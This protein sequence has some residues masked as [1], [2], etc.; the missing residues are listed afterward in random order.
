MDVKTEIEQGQQSDVRHILHA[1]QGYFTPSHGAVLPIP[2]P[3]VHDLELPRKFFHMFGSIIAW[4][5]LFADFSQQYAVL[6]LVIYAGVMLLLD[7]SRLL[8]PALNGSY[9]RFFGPLMRESELKTLNTSTYFVLG[10]LVAIA[11]FPKPVAVLSILYL[12]FGDPMA[13]II[14]MRYG[15]TRIFGKSLEGSFACFCTC[16]FMGM[17]FFPWSVAVLGAAIATISE[18]IPFPVNDN[19]RIPI[20]SALGLMLLL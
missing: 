15:K 20:I 1:E 18:V 7:V 9:T 12:A 6:L 13:A 10:S 2:Q 16:L 5:Y 17:F 3:T 14:G 11:F 8:K 19:F 4:I